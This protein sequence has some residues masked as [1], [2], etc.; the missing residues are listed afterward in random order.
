MLGKQKITQLYQASFTYR[1]LT[2][3][4]FIGL[5]PLITA[6]V[7]EYFD[8]KH[9]LVQERHRQLATINRM[10]SQ[11]IAI[12]YNA[13]SDHFTAHADDVKKLLLSLQKQ[14][15]RSDQSVTNQHL[16]EKLHKYYHH[17][18]W[19]ITDSQGIV[20]FSTN[21]S[22]L[23]GQPLPVKDSAMETALNNAFSQKKWQSFI[24]TSSLFQ[25]STH[26]RYHHFFIL[27]LPDQQQSPAGAL[28]AA[29]EIPFFKTDSDLNK[30]MI[31]YL[32]DRQRNI[33]LII[34]ENA[35]T[36]TNSVNTFSD[37]PLVSAWLNNQSDYFNNE[38]IQQYNNGQA[39]TLGIAQP[40]EIADTP[41]LLITQMPEDKALASVKKLKHYVFT[42]LLIMIF[43]AI[44]AS[45]LFAFYISAPLKQLTRNMRQIIQGHYVYT[46]PLPYKNEIGELS[47]TFSAMT[48]QLKTAH[49]ENNLQ[50]WRQQGLIEL[51]DVLRNETSLQALAEKTADWICNYLDITAVEVWFS[52][53]TLPYEQKTTL[54]AR[55]I[56][57]E[58]KLSCCT[59]NLS[60]SLIFQQQETGR[61]TL[62]NDTPFTLT[63]QTLVKLIPDPLTI[64][65]CSAFVHQQLQQASAYKSEFLATMS[66]E[67]RSPLHSILMLSQVMEENRSGNLTT[68]Q[69]QSATTIYRVGK[70]MLYMV[71]D[72]L[73]LSKVE[74]GQLKIIRETF[75][76]QEM[77]K[78]L[79]IQ[80]DIQ[81]KEKSIRFLVNNNAGDTVL[82]SDSHR[83]LQ[84]L[85]NLLS[86]AIKFTDK[87][88][89]TLTIDQLSP[90]QFTF[91]VTDTGIG[92][93][94][95]KQY[96][97]FQPFHQVDSSDSRRY[98]GTG[99]GLTISQK[100][101]TMLGGTLQ[102]KSRQ[103]EGTTFT[104]TIPQLKNI[105]EDTSQQA[106]QL[107]TFT[108]SDYNHNKLITDTSVNTQYK[109][110]Y[111]GV[112]VL[113]II[114]DLPQAF[115][116]SS[117]LEPLDIQVKLA[118]NEKA[119]KEQL[120]IK[121]ETD[122]ICLEETTIHLIE[123]LN[124]KSA[125]DKI[126]VILL[127][128]SVQKKIVPSSICKT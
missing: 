18:Q 87:G 60:L 121:P 81:A 126:P 34:S 49:E 116:L 100:L 97:I 17:N 86:N 16:P 112:S 66:H 71:N 8:A 65:L 27:P 88:S 12:Y 84:I 70:Q 120:S 99:L 29:T 45:V 5:L 91:K 124:N 96:I 92:I 2:A 101:T 61:L 6:G 55:A 93:P 21:S 110:L 25:Y 128:N 9:T 85:Q 64:S 39:I 38:T 42:L 48:L 41:L 11:E 103:N 3:F 37:N 56:K 20:L 1:L 111:S 63:Q 43:I 95:E 24:T 7:F 33:R 123:I 62:K 80:F 57:K 83:L 107:N 117:L 75:S 46:K 68:E 106:K 40:L 118:N 82:H 113:L 76:L 59:N 125:S 47:R 10:L 102:V 73:D 98:G 105:Q 79:V 50:L 51:N 74:A 26:K 119:V 69:Q 19:L 108:L 94:E 90:N 115:Y 22:H 35:D 122:I 104:L 44:A 54:L 127:T 28:I 52:K 31:S 114:K 109:N 72:I 89:V 67:L 13:V 53:T 23:T 14:Q 15:Q 36:T 77:L 78:T 4:L 32:I 30:H 58:D